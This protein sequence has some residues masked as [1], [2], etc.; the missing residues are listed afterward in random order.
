MLLSFLVTHCCRISSHSSSS[1]CC[2]SSN[3]VVSVPPD[4]TAHPSWSQM[5]VNQKKTFSRGDPKRWF[6]Y[7]SG[8][9]F[10][11]NIKYPKI[12]L[13]INLICSL[14]FVTKQDIL[15]SQCSRFWNIVFPK[16]QNRGNYKSGVKKKRDST[17]LSSSALEA[18]SLTH[19]VFLSNFRKKKSLFRSP[20]DLLNSAAHPTNGTP[21]KGK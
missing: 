11:I 14:H 2:K 17:T 13:K 10:R 3:L 6:R 18:N 4:R 20:T 5:W 21:F 7:E 16:H 1:I 15:T 12:A 8:F 9:S 19:F